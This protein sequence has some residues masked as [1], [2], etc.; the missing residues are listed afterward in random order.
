VQA[1]NDYE[2]AVILISHDRHMVELTADRLVLVD[3]G[4]AAEYAGSMADYMD[5]VLGRNP[6]KTEPKPQSSKP[7]QQSAA[8]SWN[9]QRD[10][11]KQVARAES[12]INRF[13]AQIDEIDGALIDPASSTPPLAKLTMGELARRRADLCE[14]LNAAE[15]QWLKLS[16]QLDLCE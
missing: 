1:L 3:A 16:E 6:P 11:R 13:Q 8:L 12:A 14:E 5:F 15:E 10:L 7:A 2:G 9:Q 4:T